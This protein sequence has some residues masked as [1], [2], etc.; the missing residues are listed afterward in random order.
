MVLVPYRVKKLEDGGSVPDEQCLWNSASVNNQGGET[1]IYA[2]FSVD[3]S[4][5]TIPV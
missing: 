2:L 3:F 5:V 4:P 1:E